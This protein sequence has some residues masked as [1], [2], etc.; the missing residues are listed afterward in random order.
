LA[1]RKRFIIFAANILTLIMPAYEPRIDTYIVK[2]PPYAKPILTHIREL[3]HK[4]C[5]DVEEKIKWGFPH[6][7]YRDEMMC[8]MAAFKN[9]AVFGFWK[10]SLMKDRTLFDTAQSEAAMGHS[11][12]LM[13]L[14]DLPSDKIFAGYIKEAMKLNE[15]GIKLPPREKKEQKE[16]V[17]PVYFT[18]ALKKSKKTQ[19]AFEKFPYSHKKEYI[20]WFEEAKSEDTRNKRLNQGVEWMTEG[21][22][23]NWKYMRK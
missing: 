18:A 3:V 10:A 5:P 6:F 12:K 22:S 9:H 21:K 8:S 23:R 7:D 11:G 2:A 20:E 19:S 1:E 16:L 13:S 17:L 15:D 4:A 14:K